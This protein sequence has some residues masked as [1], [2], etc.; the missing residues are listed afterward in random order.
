[1]SVPRQI[2]CVFIEVRPP[3]KHLDK[4]EGLSG[5]RAKKVRFQSNELVLTPRS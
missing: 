4:D 1:M 2:G 5:S 3:P